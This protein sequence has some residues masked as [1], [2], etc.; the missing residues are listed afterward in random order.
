MITEESSPVVATGSSTK[1]AET[2][3]FLDALIKRSKVSSA[4]K[5]LHTFTHDTNLKTGEITRVLV[6]Y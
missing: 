4:E 2:A 3:L 6:L 5:R 1:L